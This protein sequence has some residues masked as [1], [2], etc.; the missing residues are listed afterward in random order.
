MGKYQ[1]N[2]VIVTAYRITHVGEKRRENNAMPLKLE[3]GKDV[4]A[5]PTMYSRL[6]K[7]QVNVGDYWVIQADGYTFVSTKATFEKRY[8]VVLEHTE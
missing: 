5:W 4:V 2:P 1:Q 6:P 3:N 7:E 8:S